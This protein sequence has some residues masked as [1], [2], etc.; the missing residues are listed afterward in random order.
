MP[1][2]VLS[3]ERGTITNRRTGVNSSSKGPC[4]ICWGN[5]MPVVGVYQAGD[6]IYNSAPASG[7]PSGWL[8]TAD[9]NPG[10]WTTLPETVA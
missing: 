3:L 1:Y 10:L 2:S 9:G 4:Q 5:S 8:C 6:I 7:G